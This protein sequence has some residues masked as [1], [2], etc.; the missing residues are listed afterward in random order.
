M[1]A[2]NIYGGTRGLLNN[3]LQRFGVEALRASGRR[4]RHRRRA[5]RITDAEAVWADSL[6]SALLASDI[7]L[8]AEAAHAAGA[9]LV[10]DNTF[11]MPLHCQPLALGADL[12]LHSATKFIGGHNDTSA[13]A[14]LGAAAL[15]ETI[16]GVAIRL[17]RLARRSRPGWRC[18]ACARWRCDFAVPAPTRWRWPRRWSILQASHACTIPVWP[19]IPATRWRCARCATALA[20]W[21]RLTSHGAPAAV[22]DG[23]RLIAFAETLGGLMTTVVHPR[24]ASYRTLT[25]EQLAAIG[26]SQGLTRF[27]IGIEAPKTSSPMS[28]AAG[29]LPLA[30]RENRREERYR[31]RDRRGGQPQH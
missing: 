15:V 7:P 9:L 16:R 24:T 3:E 14:V 20:A 27:S 22:L 6:Q 18:A 30:M 25:L 5:G 13:G 2:S 31:D 21:F 12:V 26:V 1:A 19:A 23:L 8:L 29:A 28:Y 4:R 17:E 11:A 10:I